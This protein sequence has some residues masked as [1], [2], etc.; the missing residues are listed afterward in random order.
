MEFR[1]AT[2]TSC[3]NEIVEIHMITFIGFFLTF[4]GR[5]FL[6]QL[7]KG[8]IT[9][10]KSGVIL[11]SDGNIQGFLAY[12]EDLS[13]LYRYLIKKSFFQFAWYSLLALF[14]KPKAMVR[15]IKAF[16]KPSE[17]KR[18]E[19]Y[20]ELSSIGVRPVM[21]GKRIG[22]QLIDK[23]KLEFDESRFAYI[24]LETD[25]DGNDGVNA[26]YVSSGFKLVNTYTTPECRRMNEYRW[27][28]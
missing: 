2:N 9:H 16:L 7:Y 3:V 23:L 14:R 13:G 28:P 4:L 26:F 22:R 27:K 25:A 24:K 12:S 11:A 1:R 10:E 20:V 18:D 19:A 15:L 5:G 8:F 6:R 17:S 21:K